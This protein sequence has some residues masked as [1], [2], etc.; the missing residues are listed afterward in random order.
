MERSPRRASPPSRPAR[1]ASP[2]GTPPRP[3]G[4]APP[5]RSQAPARTARGR[6]AA[7]V[8]ATGPGSRLPSGM[9]ENPQVRGWIWRGVFSAIAFLVVTIFL[10][11]FGLVAFLVVRSVRIRSRA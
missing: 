11:P 2:S 1:P 7:A 4:A 5:A 8:R 9:P 3:A 6:A 10:S